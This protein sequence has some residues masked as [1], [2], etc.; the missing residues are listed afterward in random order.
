LIV[1]NIGGARKGIE[2]MGTLG[3]PGKYALVLGENEEESP[4]APYHVDNGYKKEDN[5]L[6]VFFP[7]RYTMSIPE[8]TNAE[9]IA[10]GL[11]SMGPRSLSALLVI[12]DHANI[13]K[14]EGWTK[15]QVKDFIMKK[16]SIPQGKAI[17][18]LRGG[19]LKNEDFIIVVAGGPGVWYGL[20]QS[21]GGFENSFVT[22]K[23]SLPKNWDKLVAK[24]KNLVPNYVSY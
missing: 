15:Q 20:L 2:D 17:I 3:N 11:T 18:G 10:T 24:Y 9:G 5:A 13:F 16:S 14:S 19:S 7:N 23:I 6:T 1:K 12:P 22:K 8:E 21:A 4:W